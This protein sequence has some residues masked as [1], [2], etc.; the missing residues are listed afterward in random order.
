MEDKLF[1]KEN[2]ASSNDMRSKLIGGAAIL[3]I[4]V[5]IVGLILVST[6][7]SGDEVASNTD[8]SE[9]VNENAD[10]RSNET[11][12]DTSVT[13]Q[14]SESDNSN[15]TDENETTENNQTQEQETDESITTE[16]QQEF[17]APEDD[18]KINIYFPTSNNGTE[19]AP[20]LRDKPESGIATDII[21]AMINGPTQEEQAQGLTKP[22][23]FGP[24]TACEGNKT[25]EY[26]ITGTTLELQLCKSLETDQPELFEKSLTTSLSEATNVDAVRVISP[27]GSCKVAT[28]GC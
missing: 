10:T 24:Q 13:D 17:S 14:T 11:T 9:I 12:E 1:I 22:W 27:D 3:L 20:A 15:T 16:S 25:F 23:S 19:I 21:V 2:Q 18:T 26:S 8:E 4:A 6:G 28:N 5:G 7:G